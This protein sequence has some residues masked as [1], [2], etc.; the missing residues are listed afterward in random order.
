MSFEESFNNLSLGGQN[1][2]EFLKMI[3]DEAQKRIGSPKDFQHKHEYADTIATHFTS[4]YLRVLYGN[5]T[6]Q[7]VRKSAEFVSSWA[8]DKATV[9][10]W[11]HWYT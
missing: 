10:W 6:N 7:D 5:E 8:Y 2:D 4:I 3:F 11:L 9:V 1:R